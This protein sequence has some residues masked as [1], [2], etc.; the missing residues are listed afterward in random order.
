MGII[1]VSPGVQT[2][3]II[4]KPLVTDLTQAIFTA[5]EAYIVTAVSEVHGVV[6]A[7]G[8]LQIEKLTGTT[9]P[10]S[11][12]SILTGTINLAGTINTVVAGTV[13]STVATKTLAVGD[14]LGGVLAGVLTGL[15]GAT[16]TITLS[17]A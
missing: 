4:W 3:T 5:D 15:L 6:S 10:G 2:K 9:I 8:T 13:T 7:S 1:S 14:R 16:V 12:T 17:R 11:G